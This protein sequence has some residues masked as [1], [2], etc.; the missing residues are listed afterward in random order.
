[1]STMGNSAACARAIVIDTRRR[2]SDP[3]C[4]KRFCDLM[5]MRTPRS[6][7]EPCSSEDR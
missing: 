2:G 1:M 4:T 5:S 6:L 3:Q 7:F